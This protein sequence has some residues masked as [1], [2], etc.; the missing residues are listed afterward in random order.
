MVLLREERLDALGVLLHVAVSTEGHEV[1]ARS[2]STTRL[3]V[4]WVTGSVFPAGMAG[5]RPDPLSLQP[6]LLFLPVSFGRASQ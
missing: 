5:Q 3:H 1:V 4:G 2:A 6:K